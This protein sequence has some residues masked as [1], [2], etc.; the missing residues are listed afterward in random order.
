M[1]SI[2]FFVS[3]SSIKNL[4]KLDTFGIRD[5]VEVQ[6]RKEVDIANL[7]HFKKIITVDNDGRYVI[8]LPWVADHILNSNEDICKERLKSTTKKLLQ[9]NRESKHILATVCF[10]LRGWEHT[11]LNIGRDSSETIPVFGLLWNKDEDN[12]S[13]DTAVL[14]CSSL[15][16]TRRNVLSITHKMFDLFGILSPIR[17]IPKLLIQRSW[18]LKIGWDTVLPD[19]YQR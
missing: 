4:W 9:K 18:N 5:P 11:S 19:D 10:D 12:L 17:L 16:L 15:N 2:S 7:S 13:C 6:S 14:K 8:H 3:G 1:S